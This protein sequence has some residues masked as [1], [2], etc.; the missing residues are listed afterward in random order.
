MFKLNVLIFMSAHLWISVLCAAN[1]SGSDYSKIRRVLLASLNRFHRKLSPLLKNPPSVSIRPEGSANGLMCLPLH[2]LSDITSTFL[3]FEDLARFSSANTGAQDL[4]TS[5]VKRKLF[6]FCPHFVTPDQLVNLILHSILHENFSYSKPMSISD[7]FHDEL[8]I[9]TTKFVFNKLD[10]SKIPQRIYY[11]ILCFLHEFSYGVDAIVP[12]SPSS[13]L[14]HTL[15]LMRSQKFPKFLEF[16]IEFKP[17]EIDTYWREKFMTFYENFILSDIN[18][19][20]DAS[21]IKEL[22]KCESI[23]QVLIA[24]IEPQDVADWKTLADPLRSC[25]ANGID[26]SQSMFDS[27]MQSLSTEEVMEMFPHGCAINSNPYLLKS[28][29][30]K[31]TNNGSPEDYAYV[32]TRNSVDTF[33]LTEFRGDAFE[34]FE[35]STVIHSPSLTHLDAFSQIIRIGRISTNQLSSLLVEFSNPVFFEI[36]VRESIVPVNM[37]Y[38]NSEYDFCTLWSPYT[39]I[40]CLEA[41]F[42]SIKSR[43][44]I[45]LLTHSAVI[46]KIYKEFITDKFDL[47]KRYSFDLTD[48]EAR[49]LSEFLKNSFFEKYNGKVVSFK[50]IVSDFNDTNLNGV[51]SS[52]PREFDDLSTVDLS[53]PPISINS[54]TI[55]NHFSQNQ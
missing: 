2:I 38:F 19:N 25:R 47:N 45:I 50:E 49:Q 5:C 6:K 31:L 44:P 14:M 3:D 54:H 55:Y 21:T 16:S 33:S 28:F 40:T 7:S 34:F 9:F 30:K 37:F 27:I 29:I 48:L 46:L 32:R 36:V 18:D 10:F 15:R 17:S 35:E 4:V 42:R 1:F 53:T 20:P 24:E 39:L 51:L 26:C 22:Y 12:C 13:W 11:Y 52:N 8:Q 43:D 41:F 23:Y